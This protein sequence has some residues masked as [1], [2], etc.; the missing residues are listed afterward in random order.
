[1][2]RERPIAAELRLL[3][4]AWPTRIAFREVFDDYGDILERA[5]QG[6]PI[7]AVEAVAAQSGD[8]FSRSF[9]EHRG[10]YDPVIQAKRPPISGKGYQGK[11]PWTHLERRSRHA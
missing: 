4:T 3:A 7:D 9:D 2:P 6:E 1:M 5:R 11:R 8:G 10:W